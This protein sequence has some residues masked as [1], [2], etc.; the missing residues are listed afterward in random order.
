MLENAIPLV[1]VFHV[2]ALVLLRL[3]WELYPAIV[4]LLGAYLEGF[5]FS[6]VLLDRSLFM[7]ILWWFGFCN[8]FDLLMCASVHRSPFLLPENSS[9]PVAKLVAQLL[10]DVCV[11]FLSEWDKKKLNGRT[12]SAFLCPCST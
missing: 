1:V 11:L 10:S 3:C 8:R 9:L 12:P 4:S 5:F 2:P 6:I 7:A